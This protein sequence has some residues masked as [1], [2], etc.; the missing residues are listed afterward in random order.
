MRRGLL[1]IHRDM[2]QLEGST[3]IIISGSFATSDA[4]HRCSV[5]PEQDSQFR[6]WPLKRRCCCAETGDNSASSAAVLRLVRSIR[7]SSTRGTNLDSLTVGAPDSQQMQQGNFA[8]RKVPACCVGGLALRARLLHQTTYF[9]VVHKPMD[10]AS[11]ISQ[12]I[13]LS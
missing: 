4:E 8:P 6:I 7:T 9:F 3:K 1:S 5:P 13:R 10:K 2:A 11:V 12:T